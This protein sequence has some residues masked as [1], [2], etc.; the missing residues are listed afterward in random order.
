MRININ[1]HLF[2]KTLLKNSQNKIAIRRKRKKTKKSKK[3]I[4][5]NKK[6][7]SKQKSLRFLY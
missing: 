2:Y 5:R 7:K 4:R 3:K 6:K 1:R